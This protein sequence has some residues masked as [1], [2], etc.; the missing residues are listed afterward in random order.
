[1]DLFKLCP[2]CKTRNAL[3]EMMCSR[4]MGDISGVKPE[5]EQKPAEAQGDFIVLRTSD[6]REI[7]VCHNDVI[8]RTSTGSEILNECKAISRKHARIIEEDGRWYVQDLN[9]TN[10]TYIDDVRLK[11]GER[12]ELKPGQKLTLSSSYHLTIVF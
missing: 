9:S 12:A 1:M 2:T 7:Q 3:T 5:E 10:E 6:G 11:A 8:G 4:C